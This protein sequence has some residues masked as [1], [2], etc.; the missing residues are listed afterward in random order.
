MV[1]LLAVASSLVGTARRVQASKSWSE[2][3]TCWTAIIGAS[4]TSKTPGLDVSKR[5]LAKIEHD[6]ADQDC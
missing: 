6:Q 3:L 5:A 4:G 1:P 2:P